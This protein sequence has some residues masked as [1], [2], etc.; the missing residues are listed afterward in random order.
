LNPQAASRLSARNLWLNSDHDS[1][2][3]LSGL[4]GIKNHLTDREQIMN[5]KAKC[6]TSLIIA[7][8]FLILGPLSAAS[9]SIGTVSLVNAASQKW[10]NPD[11]GYDVFGETPKGFEDVKR[12]YIFRMRNNRRPRY[13]SG[14]DTWNDPEKSTLYK[15]ISSVI[16]RNKFTFTTATV[17]GVSYR[18]EGRFLFAQPAQFDDRPTI[19][20]QSSKYQNGA[21][22]AEGKMAFT[23]CDC[24]D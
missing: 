7:I 19:E 8:T 9:A 6:H 1:T 15:F 16:T 10:F 11:G 14:L 5:R 2:K 24:E 22:V 13:S 4:A 3:E 21:K 17:R 12:L 18:F 20:G 23:G